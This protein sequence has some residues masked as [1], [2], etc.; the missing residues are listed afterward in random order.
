[1]RLLELQ[2]P[3]QH[4]ALNGRFMDDYNNIFS[5]VNRKK[6]SMLTLFHPKPNK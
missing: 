1:M 3:M 4:P 2:R 5:S 6:G